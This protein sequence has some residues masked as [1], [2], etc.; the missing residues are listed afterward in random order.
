MRGFERV[1]LDRTL[2]AGGVS[3]NPEDAV[4]DLERAVEAAGIDAMA[5]DEKS[6]KNKKSRVWPVTAM[7]GAAAGEG[8]G[9]K[10]G[11]LGNNRRLDK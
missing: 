11:T 5:F 8:G 2:P 1:G 3:G 4:K 9:G 7:L 10:R 6:D